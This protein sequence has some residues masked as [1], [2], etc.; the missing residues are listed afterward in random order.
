MRSLLVAAGFIVWIS[1]AAYAAVV[2][3]AG[4]SY[5]TFFGMLVIVPPIAT[6][7]AFVLIVASLV[8]LGIIQG[9]ASFV[10]GRQI[11]ILD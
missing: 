5:A 4:F 9:I 7:G 2:G 6:I 10:A 1:I 8:L 3:T 11:Y